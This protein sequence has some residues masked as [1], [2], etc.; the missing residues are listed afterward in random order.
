MA[1][2]VQG[3]LK[4]PPGADGAGIEIS[5]SVPTYADLPTSLGPGDAG[6]GYLVEADGKLYIWSGT[7]FPADGSGVEFRGP[8]GIQGNPGTA[9]AA[10]TVA[11]GTTTTGAPGSGAAVTNSGTASAAV[12]EFTVPRGAAGADGADGAAAT[13]AV[14]TTTTTAAG[15]SATVTNAGTS[16]AAVLNFGIPRGV[17]GTQWFFGNG[18]PGTIPGAVIGDAYLDFD[19]GTVYRLS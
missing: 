9:G 10:A 13:V 7:A 5:G 1:W 4:G 19:D 14:G 15:S 2:S 17:N 16:S 8:Q 18:A 12:L 3:N 11:V 6:N